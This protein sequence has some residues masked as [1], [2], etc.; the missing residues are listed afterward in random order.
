MALNSLNPAAIVIKG[1]GEAP[2]DGNQYARQDAN[3]SEISVDVQEAPEDGKQYVRKDAGWSELAPESTSLLW[4]S[5]AIGTTTLPIIVEKEVVDGSITVQHA[6]DYYII[7]KVN[8]MGS[9]DQNSKKTQITI[10]NRRTGTLGFCDMYAAGGN[11]GTRGQY[12][13]MI[14]LAVTTCEAGDEIYLTAWQDNSNNKTYN[15]SDG[16]ITVMR[17][18]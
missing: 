12:V 5:Q 7:A 9:N 10:K 2:V 1:I 18:G 4:Y 11:P 17:I 14:A 13:T 8:T 15:V 3:W 6:G 16:R